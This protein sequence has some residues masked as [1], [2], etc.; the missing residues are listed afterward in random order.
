MII[1]VLAECSFRSF[2]WYLART[3]WNVVECIFERV[4]IETVRMCFQMSQLCRVCGEPAA[5][6]HFGAFTCEGCK[7]TNIIF[8]CIIRIV[9]CNVINVII[10]N[11]SVFVTDA[12]Q[13][14]RLRIYRWL[15]DVFFFFYY[16]DFL[17]AKRRVCRDLSDFE[18]STDLRGRSYDSIVRGE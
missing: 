16:Y 1:I 3:T 8:D 7:V 14:G 10:I 4:L 13:I 11:T 17:K 6:F 15:L 2:S 9:Y 5:G 18:T 12:S